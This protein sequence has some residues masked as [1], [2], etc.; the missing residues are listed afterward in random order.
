MTGP[1]ILAALLCTGPVVQVIDPDTVVVA[2]EGARPVTLRLEGVDAP[3]SGA[4]ARCVAEARRAALAT[5]LVRRTLGTPRVEVT[6]S[7]TDR[8]RRTVGDATI[9]DG[10]WAGWSLTAAITRIGADYGV[11]TLA[12]WPHNPTGQALAPKPEWCE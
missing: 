3:E 6:A 1:L 10:D 5:G 12:P 2:C 9:L 11:V 8:Y 4:R 7:Y